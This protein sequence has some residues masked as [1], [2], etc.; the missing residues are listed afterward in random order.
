[1]FFLSSWITN[2]HCIVLF[3]C[4]YAC[5]YIMGRNPVMEASA[6]DGSDVPKIITNNTVDYKSPGYK[7]QTQQIKDKDQ[8]E[9]DIY[10]DEK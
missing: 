4:H 2:G 9:A 6:Q 10:S 1:M 7:E 3:F 5:Y 8:E